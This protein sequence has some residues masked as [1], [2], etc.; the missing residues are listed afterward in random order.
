[1]NP[2]VARRP[3][4][5]VTGNLENVEKNE[6]AKIATGNLDTSSNLDAIIIQDFGFSKIWKVI[7][8]EV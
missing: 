3:S 7:S 6:I 1:M 2:P 5:A 8:I 4:P